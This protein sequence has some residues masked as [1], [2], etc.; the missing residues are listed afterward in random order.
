VFVVAQSCCVH[1]SLEINL[2]V[3]IEGREGIFGVELSRTSSAG[4]D[5]ERQAASHMLTGTEPFW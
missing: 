5:F 3:M 1:V 2:L 4:P